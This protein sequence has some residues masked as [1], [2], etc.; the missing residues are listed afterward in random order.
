MRDDERTG[1]GE[2]ASVHGGLPWD[3]TLV[4]GS[5]GKGR[6]GLFC[7]FRKR[8]KVGGKGLRRRKGNQSGAARGEV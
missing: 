1:G 8:K 6:A 7:F 4:D 2:N 5:M 3:M